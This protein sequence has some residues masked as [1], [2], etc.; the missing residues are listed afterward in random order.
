ME[1]FSKI[2]VFVFLCLFLMNT[3][4]GYQAIAEDEPDFLS[5]TGPCN[6]TFPKDHGPHPG[7]RTEWWYYTGNLQTESGA[8]FGYQLTFFRSQRNG[9]GQRLPGGLSRFIS[10]MQLSPISPGKD[11]FRPSGLPGKLWDWQG[12]LRRP[13]IRSF[14]LKIGALK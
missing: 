3:F 14:L 4:V 6:L 5:V 12:H 9:P 13:G 2:Y 11:T 7:Y 1:Q 10:D 8:R